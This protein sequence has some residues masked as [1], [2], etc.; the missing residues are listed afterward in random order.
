MGTHREK[1]M[2]LDEKEVLTSGREGLWRVY[3]RKGRSGLSLA[4]TRGSRFPHWRMGP[5]Q[6]ALGQRI[7]PGVPSPRG[8]SRGL[9]LFFFLLIP[10]VASGLWG[11]PVSRAH[12]PLFGL[13]PHTLYQGGVGVE[14]AWEQEE[15]GE[16]TTSA[17]HYE[18]LYGIT[19]NLSAT[20]VVPQVVA[21]E[22]GPN[23]SSGLGDVG[24]RL[25]HRFWRWDRPGT[26]DAAAW[27]V[28][29]QLPTGDENAR[30]AL[31]LGQPSYLLAA[32]VAHEG[33]R[34]YGFADVRWK[35]LPEDEGLDRG[36][37]L[38]LDLAYGIRPWLREY[39]EPDLVLLV[40]ANGEWA[41][42]TRRRDGTR[43]GGGTRLFLAP[44]FLWSYRNVMA[45]G[46]VQIPVIQNLHPGAEE[47]D[48]RWT[49]ALE[50]HL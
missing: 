41:D 23:Q 18:V 37:R 29:V 28:G 21:Q 33:R 9:W 36:D 26:Q 39:L 48:L 43:V 42:Q 47:V 40:E 24:L 6:G 14:T 35:I 38:T 20:L 16:A 13:G 30:P 25:K 15:A 10:L 46:G 2:P 49:L 27:V 45:K 5:L 7:S 8:P 50:V 34:H 12:E 4:A 44:G 19:P 17:L 22:A 1:G 31:G 32:T 3:S 11:P